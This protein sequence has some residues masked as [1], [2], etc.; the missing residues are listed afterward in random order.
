MCSKVS[1]GKDN[2]TASQRES[3]L[4]RILPKSIRPYALTVLKWAVAGYMIRI[5]IMPLFA[6]EDVLT[7]ALMSLTLLEKHQLYTIYPTLAFLPFVSVY[8]LL[9]PFLPRIF[10]DE[11]SL[12]AVYR[13][14][15]LFQIYHV[16][17]P[18]IQTF[19]FASKIPMLVFDFALAFLL[20]HMI[21]DEKK[22]VLAFKLWMLCPISIFIS[23]FFGQFDVIPTFFM[24]LGLYLFKKHRI[25]W[26]MLS[27]GV[28]AAFKLF[29]LIFVPAL[30]LVYIG[31]HKSLTSKVKY[32][33]L[34][35][36]TSILPFLISKIASL[37]IPIYYESAN[38]A[39]LGKFEVIGFWGNTYYIRSA[40]TNPLLTEL[41]YF[42]FSAD[43]VA[44]AT[45]RIVPY[46]FPWAY[47]L[48]LFGVAYWKKWSLERIFLTPLLAFY[49]LTPFHPQWFF[50]ILPLLVLMAAE[51]RDWFFKLYLLFIP[52]YFIFICAQNAHMTSNLLSPTVPQAYYWP[53]P[54]DL[55]N[56]V[57]IPGYEVIYI[58]T[59]I[60]SATFLMYLILV[61][62]TRNADS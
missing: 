32:L 33:F 59:S 58:F 56:S 3:R 62:K 10:V 36:G 44:S 11:I 12:N 21:N 34:M 50:W 48:F 8:A 27:L 26:S 2:S 4:Y 41:Y 13:P 28:C 22:A 29:G 16:S 1:N 20:L 45:S 9:G 39:L 57:G 17:Q 60:F 55:L 31:E 47:S 30:I 37:A 25:K 18:G 38:M 42:A 24:M 51:Y 19:I 14:V 5:V 6:H 40:V 15:Q 7:N 61:L 53:G 46:L 52:L 23:Y 35:F 49:F 43:S 54:I